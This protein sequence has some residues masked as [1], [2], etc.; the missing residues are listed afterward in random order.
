MP[1]LIIVLLIIGLFSVIAPMSASKKRAE[2]QKLL[3]SKLVTENFETS[4]VL[5]AGEMSLYVDKINEKWFI[6]QNRSDI[7]PVIY[8]FS[9]LVSFV[10]LESGNNIAT[11]TIGHNPSGPLFEKDNHIEAFLSKSGDCSSL[12]LIIRPEG[13]KTSQINVPFLKSQVS[14]S[15]HE[16]RRSFSEARYVVNAVVEIQNTVYTQ[17]ENRSMT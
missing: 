17:K 16:Y 3:T 11:A 7:N 15:S 4:F 8:P 1:E 14:R 2:M 10:L 13:E 9:A 5:S 6:R 12:L